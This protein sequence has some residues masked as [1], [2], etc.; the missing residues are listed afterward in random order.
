MWYL[1]MVSSFVR[2][3]GQTWKTVCEKEGR[4]MAGYT[5]TALALDQNKPTSRFIIAVSVMDSNGLGIQNLSERNFTVQNISRDTP[6]AVSELQSAG[7]PGFYR[8]LLKIE[9]VASAGN[10]ILAL[11][12]T[13][14]HHIGGRVPEGMDRGQTMVKVSVV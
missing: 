5:V 13:S 11:G 1:P 14:H 7:L 10:Q 2:F 6:V 8:L 3:Y 4:I 9:P 12:V